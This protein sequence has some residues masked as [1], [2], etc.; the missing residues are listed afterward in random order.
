[1][2]EFGEAITEYFEVVS[3]V[4]QIKSLKSKRI[5]LL[6]SIILADVGV[7]VHLFRYDTH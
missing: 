7:K 1:M 2:F 6:V 4:E 5:Q 3:S